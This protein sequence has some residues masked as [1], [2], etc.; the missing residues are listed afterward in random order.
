MIILLVGGVI[1]I[2]S[3]QTCLIVN[4]YLGS[5]HSLRSC[6]IDRYQ[7]TQRLPSSDLYNHKVVETRSDQ[8]NRKSSCRKDL[9]QHEKTRKP[10]SR[11]REGV[12][13]IARTLC[14]FSVLNVPG[15]I[16]IYTFEECFPLIDVVKKVS[17]FIDIDGAGV[18]PVKHV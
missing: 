9:E 3:N 10:V 1:T 18:I 4:V 8:S 7:K 6:Q 16:P 11:A 15:T 14:E 17:E 13:G 12:L 5:S 2:H